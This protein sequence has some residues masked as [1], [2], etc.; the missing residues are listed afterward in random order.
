L[1]DNKDPPVPEIDAE[2]LFLAMMGNGRYPDPYMYPALLKLKA[3]GKYKLVALSNNVI[4]PP[5]HP[6]R[7]FGHDDVRA[8]FEI[9]IG[10]ASI[11]MRKPERRA[12]EYAMRMIQ[13]RWGPEIEEKDVL[14]LDDIGE[15][16]KVARA[17][18]MRTL[19]VVLGKSDEAVRE[20]EEMTGLQ[21]L[22]EAGE[23]RHESQEG[24]GARRAGGGLRL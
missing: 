2:K 19:K 14:F 6:L 11:G 16:L 23:Q 21:L 5:G 17:L 7:A 24:K 3:S 9:F 18:G 4:F 15:N 8:V 22:G 13:E 20:L 10:S 1:S 12:Y